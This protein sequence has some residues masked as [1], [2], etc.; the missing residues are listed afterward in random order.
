M[1]KSWLLAGLVL[2]LAHADSAQIDL[3]AQPPDESAAQTQETAPPPEPISITVQDPEHKE[4]KEYDNRIVKAHIRIKSSWTMMEIKET[5]KSGAASFTLSRVP[6]VT[7]AIVRDPLQGD[8]E[9]YISSEALTSLYPSGFKKGQTVF[10]GRKAVRIR[11]T[12]TD[13]RLEES[14]FSTDGSSLY[15]VAFTAPPESWNKVQPQF[16]D[17]KRSFRWLP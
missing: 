10:A 5:K 16:D 1:K 9:E 13:N 12:A 15:R 3:P 8:F 17:L 14:Y 2:S 7:F 11:G 6:L 4:W